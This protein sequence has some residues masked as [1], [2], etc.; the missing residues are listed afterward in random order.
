[1]KFICSGL[2]LYQML[3]TEYNHLRQHMCFIDFYEEL[4]KTLVNRYYYYH[5]AF[6]FYFDKQTFLSDLRKELRV[7]FLI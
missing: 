5:I 1:M 3:Q 4:P 6:D 7:K 2:L